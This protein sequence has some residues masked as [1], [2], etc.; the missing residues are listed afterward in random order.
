MRL[1]SSWLVVCTLLL[2]STSS[3]AG[4]EHQ[5][6]FAVELALV[7]GDS[8]LLVKNGLS[9]KLT[10]EKRRWIKTRITG[11]V[12]VL[13]LLARYSLQEAGRI[14][15]ALVTRLQN[16][17]KLLDEPSK[18]YKTTQILTRQNP[19]RFSLALPQ[20][21]TSLAN[22]Q[23]AKR[24]NRLC[25]GCHA[26]PSME[27]SVVVGGLGSF[28]RSMS[29]NEWLARLIGGLHG[30]AYTGLENPFTDREIVMFFSYIREQL[31]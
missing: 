15:T 28:A 8:R 27:R 4:G 22:S 29:Q 11:A 13:P 3:L 5:R 25:F 24:Y 10:E 31:P 14:D 26:A 7:A 30:D 17:Q 23:I 16:L 12:N 21:L 6:R 1:I 9:N 19:L 2:Y 18:L 20:T